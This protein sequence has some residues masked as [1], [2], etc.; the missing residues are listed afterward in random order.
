MPIWA[1]KKAK[2]YKLLLYKPLRAAVALR[3]AGR[4]LL[5]VAL[6]L[7]PDSPFPPVASVFA[8]ASACAKA[9]T[10]KSPDKLGRE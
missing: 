2:S 7:P 1:W 8:K 10:D 3:S 6:V 5:K 4:V 9:S